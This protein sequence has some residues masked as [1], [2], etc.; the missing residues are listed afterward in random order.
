MGVPHFFCVFF[1]YLYQKYL[2]EN[3]EQ[4]SEV[5]FGTDE[6]D[7]IRQKNNIYKN[8]LFFSTILSPIPRHFKF[9]LP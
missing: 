4:P 8:V 3:I 2:S 1:V 5:F 9:T 7:T 6:H